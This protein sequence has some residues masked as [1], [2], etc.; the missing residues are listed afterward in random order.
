MM[1][2]I[3]D[4]SIGVENM[5]RLFRVTS[6]SRTAVS[7]HLSVSIDITESISR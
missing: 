1:R 7:S 5:L 3:R 2:L 4:D 6:L